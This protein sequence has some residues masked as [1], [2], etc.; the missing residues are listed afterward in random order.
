MYSRPYVSLLK[1][2]AFFA[3]LGAFVFVRGI[4]REPELFP[5]EAAGIRRIGAALFALG[6]LLAL[7]VLRRHMICRALLRGGTPLDAAYAVICRD[8]FSGRRN[9]PK[10][11][12]VRLRYVHGG[13]VRYVWSGH[14]P[15]APDLDCVP[16]VLAD[17]RRPRR[18]IVDVTSLYKP[19]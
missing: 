14:L 10:P 19:R 13:R 15:A 12:V 8:R 17:P 4:L 1:A 5:A 11:F 7:A 16:R 2:A 9:S 18:A 6:I 3:V